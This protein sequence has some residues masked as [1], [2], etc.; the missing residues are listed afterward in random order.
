MN[1]N[2]IGVAEKTFTSMLYLNKYGIT[3]NVIVSRKIRS[4]KA[5]LMP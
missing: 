2:L 1:K 4:K 3:L 5:Y